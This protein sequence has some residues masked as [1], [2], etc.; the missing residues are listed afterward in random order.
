LE[1]LSKRIFMQA[2]VRLSRR[3]KLFPKSFSLVG[4][5]IGQTIV[6]TANVNIFRGRHEGREVCLKKYR[7]RS[8]S[9]GNGDDMV[10]V[11]IIHLRRLHGSIDSWL[12][13][14]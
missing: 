3:A 10:E 8:Q 9:Y 13:S 5:E 6:E 4:V 1:G 11:C 7:R 12:A 2:L 14:D